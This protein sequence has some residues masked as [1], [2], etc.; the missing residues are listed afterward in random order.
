MTAPGSRVD[1]AAIRTFGA[2]LASRARAL[3]NEITCRELPVRFVSRSDNV[4]IHA[5][6]TFFP[7]SATT[8][9]LEVDRL[10]MVFLPIVPYGSTGS[11]LR[12]AAL[13][14]GYTHVMTVAPANGYVGAAA[15]P[16][17]YTRVSDEADPVYLDPGAAAL[18]AERAAALLPRAES[19]AESPVHA[20]EPVPVRVNAGLAWF[21]ESG[22]PAEAGRARGESMRALLPEG[23]GEA[24][25]F[26]WLRGTP[27]SGLLGHWQLLRGVANEQ[28]LA[29]A[30]ASNDARR[31]LAALPSP[32]T[33][34]L[35]AASASA[36]IALQRLWLMQLAPAESAGDELIS[37]VGVLFSAASESDGLLI[38]QTLRWPGTAPAA[39]TQATPRQGHAYAIAGMPWHMSGA[40]GINER[41]IVLAAAPSARS[42][43][44]AISAPAEVLFDETLRRAGTLDEALAILTIPRDGFRG[45][46]LVGSVERGLTQPVIVEVGPVPVVLDMAPTDIIHRDA[47]APQADEARVARLLRGLSAP[48]AADFERIVSDRD[49]RAQEGGRV[50]TPHTRACVVLV[51]ASREMRIMAPL[52]GEPREFERVRVGGEGS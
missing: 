52:D 19:P 46:I 10:A 35:T 28:S 40:C 21:L 48:T 14:A 30:L 15:P 27:S 26:D 3:A 43:E 41:G 50:L 51:P 36:G 31:L 9:V 25:S 49:R 5:A 42:T 24:V 12:S 29:I 33:E 47:I 39:V 34:R 1:W 18:F 4:P 11:T 20:T 45:R 32:S 13:G 8:Q 22:T 16:D 44:S 17:G 38:G 2:A 6:S 23:L 37:G 7:V